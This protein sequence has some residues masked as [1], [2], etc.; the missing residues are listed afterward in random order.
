[1]SFKTKGYHLIKNALSQEL[2]KFSCDYLHLKAEIYDTFREKRHISPYTEDWGTRDDEQVPKAFS[3]YGDPVMEILLKKI[4]PV[5]EKAIKKSLVETYSFARIYITGN[6]LKRHKDRDACEI[7]T[8]LNLGGDPWPIYIEP[9]KSKGTVKNKK[10]IS[11]NTPGVEIILEPGDMLV[12]RGIDLEHW[13]EPFEGNS[14]S[15]VF[16][17]YN[18]IESFGTKNLYD[19]RIHLGL[20]RMPYFFKNKEKL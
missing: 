2:T 15:Q 6:E 13:R 9:D 5:L 7:S 4:K 1:M 16:L 12:Y 20:P 3:I 14:C 19:D 8:T 11:E 18:D 10:Y 17:H